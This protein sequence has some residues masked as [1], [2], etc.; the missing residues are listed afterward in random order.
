MR[1]SQLHGSQQSTT[2]VSLSWI[3]AF[4][5]S[6][7]PPNAVEAKPGLIVIRVRE[8]SDV[9]PGKWPTEAECAYIP[10]G[11]REKSANS[12]EVLCNTSLYSERDP[13]TWIP[14]GAGYIPTEAIQGG[15]TETM[16]PL[17]IAR[18]M[19]NGEWCVGKVHPSHDCAYFPWGGGEHALQQY[20]LL[21]YRN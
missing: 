9:L 3:P 17:Y 18:A 12:F 5:N 11:G 2:E 19:V 15:V 7:P 8:V 6:S 1:G 13:Y 16:E 14:S 20:E 10:Y 21:C 4:S